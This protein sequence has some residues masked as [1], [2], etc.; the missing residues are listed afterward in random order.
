[1]A[2]KLG[3][4]DQAGGEAAAS[5]LR[6]I[7]PPSQMTPEFSRA[8]RCITVVAVACSQHVVVAIRDNA[9]ASYSIS[10]RVALYAS[11]VVGPGE[12]VTAA[13]RRAE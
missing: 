8:T 6:I 10:D 7:F 1:V 2:P 12:I 5:I 11:V 3:G 13:S 4:I 9:A